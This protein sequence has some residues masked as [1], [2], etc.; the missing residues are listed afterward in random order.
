MSSQDDGQEAAAGYRED[1]EDMNRGRAE[2]HLR[3]PKPTASPWSLLIR[4]F[5]SRISPA[6]GRS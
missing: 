6:P 1:T 3:R 2:T 4:Y 5:G